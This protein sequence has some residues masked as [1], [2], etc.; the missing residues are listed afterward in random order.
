MGKAKGAI[1]LADESEPVEG[2]WGRGANTPRELA[3]SLT[4]EGCFKEVTEGE[5]QRQHARKEN[6]A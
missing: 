1:Y 5:E 3:L 2:L 4:Q 6:W